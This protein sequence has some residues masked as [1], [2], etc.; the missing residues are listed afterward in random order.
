MIHHNKN[1][2]RPGSTNGRPR[3]NIRRVGNRDEDDGA[4]CCD[5]A[6]DVA[7]VN[8]EED[9]ADDIEEERDEE[10]EEVGEVVEA[11]G[12]VSETGVDA[13]DW[14]VSTPRCDGFP[15]F[16]DEEGR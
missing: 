8:G 5:A 1:C 10:G 7:G 9:G 6:A 14:R 3:A 13:G 16:V 4:D 2:P 11:W 12:E 15:D